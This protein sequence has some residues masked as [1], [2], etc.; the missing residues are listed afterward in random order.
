MKKAGSDELRAE[1]RRED[2]GPGV[3]GKYHGSFRSGTNLVLLHPDV[4]RAFPTDEAVNK[5]L[6][7]FM[8]AAEEPD[9]S[10]PSGPP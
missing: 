9:D 4:A 5:A 3:R 10:T 2:L 8:G 7:S 6:R 1:Y